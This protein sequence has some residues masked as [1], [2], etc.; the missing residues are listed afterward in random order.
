VRRSRELWLSGLIVVLALPVHLTGL[1]VPTIYRDP[2]V[3]LPQN[4]GTDLVTL[5]LGIP[6]LA[7]AAVAMQGGSQRARVFWLGALGLLVYVYGMYALGVRWNRLFL[8][9]VALFGLSLF[10]LIIGL[11]GTDAVRIRAGLKARAPVRSVAA[12][13]IVIAVMVAAMWL[14]EEMAAL[15]R[16]A[17]PPTVL[18]FE[19]PTN[20]VHVFDLAVVLPAM[21]LAAVMLLRDRLW[22]YVLAGMLLVKATAI[23]LWVIAM[24]WFSAR[25]GIGTPAAYAGFFGLL[26]AVGGMFTWRFL[27]A[28]EP[29][30]EAIPRPAPLTLTSSMR[31]Q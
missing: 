27:S 30:P 25:R 6:L 24:I 16:G 2:D 15:L 8:L 29:A 28:L 19:T 5:L 1:L 10:T 14:A 4:L 18:Q 22:G 3:V 20:I 12:Y 21:A 11:V 17:V 26:T 23:G 7:A 9:Y 13:L 31:R